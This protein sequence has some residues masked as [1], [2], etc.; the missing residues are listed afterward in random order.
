MSR[1]KLLTRTLF[2][3]CVVACLLWLCGCTE[4][5]TN[6]QSETDRRDTMTLSGSVAV[7][8]PA[9]G[10]AVVPIELTLERNGSETLRMETESK[11]QI[12]AQAIAQQVGA[13]VGK[14]LD[15]AIAKLTGLQLSAK[16]SQ[17]WDITPAEGTLAG[18]LAGLAMFAGRE[19]MARRRL[20][21]QRDELQM[22]SIELAKQVP[23]PVNH[24]QRMDGGA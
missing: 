15:A 3:L 7:P 24:V 13:V 6:T 9:G 19:Y 23:P 12:D 11:T 5:R 4:T 8:M 22:Q 1:T 2:I 17:P 18:G 20:V 14:S 21:R 10:T 16:T